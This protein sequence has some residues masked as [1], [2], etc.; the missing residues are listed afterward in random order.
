MHLVA[1]ES[2]TVLLTLLMSVKITV[3]IDHLPPVLALI[4]MIAQTNVG[5]MMKIMLF[6]ATGA[7][8]RIPHCTFE[9]DAVIMTY[10]LYV[11]LPFLIYPNFFYLVNETIF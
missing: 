4:S 8:A 1:Q 11:K 9:S 10:R 3:W 5:F 2:L 6:Q 7:A